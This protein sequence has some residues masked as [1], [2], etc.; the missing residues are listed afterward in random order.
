MTLT[1]LKAGEVVGVAKTS[2]SAR[3][4]I[5]TFDGTKPDAVGDAPAGILM[6]DVPTNTPH[7]EMNAYG[8]GSVI[9]DSGLTLAD[10]DLVYSDGDG[11]YSAS[12]PAGAA[13]TKVWVFGVPTSAT[14]FRVNIFSYEKGA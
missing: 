8:I 4:V 6:D 3:G 11:T 2:E 10:T 13:G 1:L 9:D 14:A 5:V 7:L 12:E